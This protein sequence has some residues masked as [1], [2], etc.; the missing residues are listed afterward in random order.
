LCNYYGLFALEDIEENEYI[1]E[2]SGELLSK[3]ETDRRSVFNDQLGLNYLFGL[4]YSSDIDAYRLGS[5]MRY[6]NHSSHG[7]QNCYARANFVRGVY[8]I[9]LF[10]LRNIKKGEELYFDY[11]IKVNVPWL[12]K[13]DRYYS[14]KK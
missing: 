12:M 6:V 1:C 2:Y 13:Y 14:S 8:R 11:M 7:Y 4:S 3:E 5:K 9:A 10:A